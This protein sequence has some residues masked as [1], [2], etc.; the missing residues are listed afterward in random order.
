MLNLLLTKKYTLNTTKFI[1]AFWGDLNHHDGRHKIEIERTSEYQR[2]DEVVYVWG[3]ENE[4]FIKSF[5]FKTI[6]VNDNPFQYGIDYFED[7]RTF[8]LHKL[9]AIYYGIRDYEKV[10]F[11]DWDIIPQKGIDKNFYNQLK[12][13]F[14]IPLYSFP[15]DYEDIVLAEWKDISFRDKRYL[16]TQN[17]LIQ[18]YGWNFGDDKVI[19]NT[20]FVYCDDIKLIETFIHINRYDERTMISDEFPIL[21]YF[22]N[23]NIGLNEYITKYEP[24]VSNA[25]F[26]THFNQKL[27][28]DYIKKIIKKDLYFIHE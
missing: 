7:C 12:S 17:R 19:P 18:E 26:E 16:H 28:N 3:K 2:L 14:Q 22:K 11:L 24:S 4:K 6:L 27:L 5:G 20:S 15:K 9:M 23:K 10:V 13:P 21:Y 8:F 25:K 1:R